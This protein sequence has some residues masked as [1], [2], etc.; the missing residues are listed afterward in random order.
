MIYTLIMP[1]KIAFFDCD[2]T[3]TQIRSSWEYLHRR[4]K[5]WDNHADEYQVLFREGKIDYQQ[6][7]RRDALLWQ[8]LS[9]ESVMDIIKEVPYTDGCR[10]IIRFCRNS[11]IATVIV[12]TGLSLLV[13]HV[14][15]NLGVDLAF[16][17]ELTEQDGRL[18]GEARVR[19]E[20]NRKGDIVRSILNRFGYRRE[21][22]CAIGDGDG[23]IGMFEEVALPVGFHPQEEILPYIKHTL[24][25][26]SLMP[27][28][29]LIAGYP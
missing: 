6:F 20:Y 11:G 17:N 9:T 25:D 13:E 28:I 5:I 22:A 7:C 14:R 18:T 16:A 4:L 23:D 2:G 26:G 1:I 12:S 29:G 8:G 24:S 3:L 19:V 15:S 21:E 10:E 27:L